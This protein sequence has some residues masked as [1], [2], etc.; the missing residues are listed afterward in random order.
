MV[1]YCAVFR[2]LKTYVFFGLPTLGHSV[3]TVYGLRSV[4]TR[5]TLGLLSPRSSD[6]GTTCRANMLN[7]CVVLTP[8]PS[9][10]LTYYLLTS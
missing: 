6:G 7:I 8:T 2:R 4:Y 10:V 1:C 3:Y 5:S 9:K